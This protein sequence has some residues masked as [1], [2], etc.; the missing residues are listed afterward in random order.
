M[1]HFGWNPFALGNQLSEPEPPKQPALEIQYNKQ[2][3]PAGG[4]APFMASPEDSS[5]KHLQLALPASSVQHAMPAPEVPQPAQQVQLALP[6]P[7]VQPALPAESGQNAK[8]PAPTTVAQSAPEGQDEQKLKGEGHAAGN[9]TTN[10]DKGSNSKGDPETQPGP[11][12]DKNKPTTTAVTASLAKLRN[13]L[14]KRG[15]ADHKIMK[16]PASKLDASADKNTMKRPA[17][18]LDASADKN[19]LKRPTSKLDTSTKAESSKGKVM[20]R[21]AAAPKASNSGS[22]AKNK[23]T[24]KS[25]TKNL[26]PKGHGRVM[27]GKAQRLRMVPWGCA[28]CRQVPGC[29]PSCWTKKGWVKRDD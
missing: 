15:A 29:T 4:G 13:A 20:K 10:E 8:L 14:D 26:V 16:R 23:S 25:L 7:E 3:L 27:P 11:Q 6:P 19:T 9:A 1:A 22:A 18:K 24:M 2:M 28:T 21:P 5:Q 17:S 12:L